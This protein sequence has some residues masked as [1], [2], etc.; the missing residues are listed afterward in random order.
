MQFGMLLVAANGLGFKSVLDF[1]VVSHA[2]MRIRLRILEFLL[3]E[4][5]KRFQYESFL[6]PLAQASVMFLL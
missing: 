2:L 5:P 4:N 1:L 3:F 6:L